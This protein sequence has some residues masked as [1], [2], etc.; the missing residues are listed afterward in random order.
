VIGNP[1]KGLH[2]VVISIVCQVQLRPNEE[3]L[4]VVADHPT[5][6]P[7]ILVFDGHAGVQQNILTIWM[8][9]DLTQTLPTV[10]IGVT[11]EKMD[12]SIYQYLYD[13]HKS[14]AHTGSH[15][16]IFPVLVLYKR[17]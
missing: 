3:N 11:F 4:L 8:L 5:I 6:I 2:L 7:H 1:S 13:C 16:H 15:S 10:Q 14:R 12:P 9:Y 17:S